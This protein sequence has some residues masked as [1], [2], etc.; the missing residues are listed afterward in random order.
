MRRALLDLWYRG[1]ASVSRAEWWGP[2]LDEACRAL[3][4]LTAA[5]LSA[6]P[7]PPEADLSSDHAALAEVLA[8]D[9]V[10]RN[11]YRKTPRA[12]EGD[13]RALATAR[14]AV[15]A[16][17][18]GRLSHDSE[19]LFL[20]MPFMH[21]EERAAHVEAAPL[22]PA[23]AAEFAREHGAVVARFGRFP[24]RNAVLGRESTPDEAAHL[25]SSERRRWEV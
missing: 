19:R 22:W 10:T 15:A 13:A 18:L 7:P 12:F 16:G 6:T 23:S 2:S 5:L 25:A 1:D 8:L 3:L 20:L 14:A 21:A 9:Q 17:A 24:H 4:P 11:C